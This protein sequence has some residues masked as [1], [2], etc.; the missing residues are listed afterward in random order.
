MF[1]G[2][3]KN[4][5]IDYRM[6]YN[7]DKPLSKKAEKKKEESDKEERL[8]R[9]LYLYKRYPDRQLVKDFLLDVLLRENNDKEYGYVT[10]MGH[11]KL[12]LMEKHLLWG[13]VLSPYYYS[14]YRRYVNNMDK[15]TQFKTVV[16]YICL[17]YGIE[18]KE[19]IKV[20]YGRERTIYCVKLKDI[21]NL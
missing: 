16:R 18:Y 13:T 11:K 10:M 1:V 4:K 5:K 2:K 9:K 3:T 21:N 17:L 6:L 20:E 7:V 15:F 14:K 8:R 12:L 19:I